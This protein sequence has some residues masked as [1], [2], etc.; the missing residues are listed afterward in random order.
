MIKIIIY[1]ARES[2]QKLLYEYTSPPLNKI[3]EVLCFADS[4]P[5]LWDTEIPGKKIINPNDINN[6]CFDKIIIGSYSSHKEIFYFLKDN[7]GISENLIDNSDIIFFDKARQLFLSYQAKILK[8]LG[9]NENSGCVAEVGVFRGDFAKY[10][11]AC[12]PKNKLY[13]FDTFTGHDKRDL[14]FE[15]SRNFNYNFSP[16]RYA[17]TSVE[18][19]KNNLPY[20]EN[21]IF[22]TGYF[23]DT[24]KDI[25]EN[26]IFVSIDV[27]LY[28]P[29]FSALEYFY[30]RML[31][32]GVILCHDYF[33]WEVEPGAHIAID[34]FCNKNNIPFIAIGDRISIAIIRT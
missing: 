25:E 32:G 4:N 5:A 12:F 9:Y 30:P 26:F 28:S 3:Y 29:T 13:L 19:V 23:P 27:N 33:S 15:K 17:Q 34:E 7:L 2:G 16:E 31:Y 22:R 11:N 14:S 8:E 6:H 24:T 1:G 20:P 18:L 21:A 10:I